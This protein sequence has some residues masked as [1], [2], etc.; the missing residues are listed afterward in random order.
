MIAK[1][2]FIKNMIWFYLFLPAV[3]RNHD[4]VWKDSISQTVCLKKCISAKNIGTFWQAQK[5]DDD[6]DELF[7]P[8][9]R[10]LCAV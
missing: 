9:I 10:F 1:K 4:P 6:V 2:N 5:I 3:D 8:Q 7:V